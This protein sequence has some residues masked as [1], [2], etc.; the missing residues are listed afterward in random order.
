MKFDISVIIPT[1]NVESFIEET[2]LSLKN[3]TF[4]GSF[5]VIVIDDC[6]TDNTLNIV[7]EFKQNYPELHLK[8]FV[9]KKNMRQG[10]ARNR[11]VR[12]S[13]GKYIFFLDGDDFIDP[14]TFEKMFQI[15]EKNECD[16][17]LCDWV[18]YY[19]D[20]GKVYVNSDRFLFR[21]FLIDDQVEMLL[22]A[23][24]YFT[25]NKLYRKEFLE[26]YNIK[27][28]EGYIYEDFEFYVKVAQY[29]SKVG[30]VQNPYYRVRV[31]QESTTKTNTKGTLHIDSL[32][33]AVKNT[34][35][36][37]DPRS[38]YG[39]YHLYKYLMRKTLTYLDKRA[40]KRYRRQ[41]LK[42]IVEILNE[43]STEYNVPPRVVPLYHFLF[44][45]KYLQH[46]DI[47]K[48]QLIWYLHK[49]G[50][51]RKLFTLALKIK[52]AILSFAKKV[53]QK[54]RQKLIKSF[55]K[56]PIEKGSILFLGF[57]YRYV[58]NS[59]YFFDYIKNSK[60]VGNIYF[61]TENKNVPAEYRIKP[62]SNKFYEKL[63]VANLVLVESWVPLAFNK[64]EG[65]T[66]IQ[67]WHGTPF[68]KVFFDSHEFYISHFNK[69][70]KRNKQRDIRRWD[71]LLA[72]SE[73]GV[74]K[75]STSFDFD[76]NKI[77]LYGYPRVQWLKDN[78][79]NIELKNK[80]R[81]SL[82]IKKDK[83]VLLYVPTWR[84]YNYK[85]ID[86]DWSYLLDVDK[87]DKKLNGEYVIIYK[88]H[89][90]GKRKKYGENIIIP[91]ENVETQELLLI[92]DLVISDYSSIIFDALAID[93]PFY[94]YITDFEEYLKARGV[95][96]DMHQ[97]LSPFYVDNV[98]NLSQKIVNVER[99][100]PIELYKEIKKIYS[101][102]G[103]INS[104]QLL[105]KKIMEIIRGEK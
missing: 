78:Q 36:D 13:Q 15:A 23:E 66:W 84:D 8:I 31:N 26:K 67:L 19:E 80:I 73:V 96:E 95:Y 88:E 63:A 102:D 99:Q 57:D 34:L 105:E 64:R 55:Y 89:S 10:T 50:K 51:L 45:R 71:Y 6:S 11:G 104:N 47:S 49:K 14:N 1:Y 16:F 94:L 93:I 40:P 85:K 24:T 43:K 68:K 58:G 60:E 38:H 54:K 81:Q 77:L 100:Y 101:F 69:N 33:I 76:K 56:R 92:S 29:A 91:D 22:E 44:R 12:E 86:I 97:K 70:H 52:N 82:N 61:V 21:D 53:K 62:R 41:T 30:I 17:V 4:Q 42:K 48:I 90:M 5:E 75:L 28:G 25:V 32:I 59:K 103:E 74:E 79:N 98:N 7:K 87:L 3:Q 39:Y 83:K 27:Y 9:Q 65:S 20:K 2:L 46:G 37:F 35:K 72:D 18:Y